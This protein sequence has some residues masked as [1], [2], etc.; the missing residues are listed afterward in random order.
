MNVNKKYLLS[1]TIISVFVVSLLLVMGPALAV[2]VGVIF[3]NDQIFKGEDVNFQVNVNINTDERIPISYGD[4]GI[5]DPDGQVIICLFDMQG[6]IFG[7][8]E[9]CNEF[10]INSISF[11]PGS[12][13]EDYGYL[14]GYDPNYARWYFFG[15]GYGY[16]NSMH[17]ATVSVDVTWS[18]NGNQ[19]IGEHTAAAAIVSALGGPP[20]ILKEAEVINPFEP[21]A[22]APPYHVFVSGESTF[23][24]I[25]GGTIHG[26]GGT[27][28]YT[29]G[30]KT[31]TI[32]LSQLGFSSS[33]ALAVGDSVTF[34]FNGET[35]TG[36][37]IE[38][39]DGYV[40]IQ[41]ASTPQNVTVK[42]GE[43]VNVDVNYDGT[44]D[45]SIFLEK[46][47]GGKAYLKFARIGG[48]AITTPTTP[49]TPTE[50]TTPANVT[51]TKPAPL[52]STT[53]LVVV[54]ILAIVL[55]AYGFMKQ[56]GKKQHK[57]K[58]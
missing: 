10:R 38:I 26:G 14:R 3:P 30:S 29:P 44:N 51:E 35:H 43:T 31:Y 41:V 56:K 53:I 54:V 57:K 18:A 21:I 50:P 24:I 49:L 9:R 46:I 22:N 15:Y 55:F 11:S 42:T 5:M 32:D 4:F 7:G 16:G 12:G 23:S 52:D 2:D 25:S 13:Y 8:D 20:L 48:G 28:G 6:N 27:G 36:T 19:V 39:G 37:I 58:R 34:T 40:I 1:S 17:G 47:D 33:K 45:I